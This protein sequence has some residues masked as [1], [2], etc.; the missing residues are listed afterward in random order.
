M[1]AQTAPKEIVRIATAGAEM[2]DSS[3]SVA[4]AGVGTGEE[5]VGAEEGA[6]VGAEEGTAVGVEEGAGVGAEQG[7]GVGT[8][9]GAEVGAEEG[10]EVAVG[11]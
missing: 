2:H 7:A 1:K 9:G 10:A 8:E 3:E 11:T 6:G 5:G 4:G